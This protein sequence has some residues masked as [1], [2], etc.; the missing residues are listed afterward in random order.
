VTWKSPRREFGDGRPRPPGVPRLDEAERSTSVVGRRHLEN[1]RTALG[2]ACAEGRCPDQ[3]PSE[4]GEGHERL[5]EV[6][7]ALLVLELLG[8][9][10]QL[11]AGRIG[12]VIG[13]EPL[14]PSTN[15]STFRSGPSANRA[16]SDTWFS[17][18]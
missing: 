3:L 8:E 2:D 16:P 12:L 6:G 4:S 7:E 13:G 1:A 9:R 14:G 18:L 10:V 17:S 11:R 5:D 15:L